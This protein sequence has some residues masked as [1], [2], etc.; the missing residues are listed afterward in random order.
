M[1]TVSTAYFCNPCARA[2]SHQ[3]ERARKLCSATLSSLDL[4][5]LILSRLK[6]PPKVQ[7]FFVFKCHCADMSPQIVNRTF[8]ICK[9]Q[10]CDLYIT[11]AIYKSHFCDLYIT[12][13]IYK[14]HFCDLYITFAIYKSHFCDLYITFTICKSHFCDLYITFA[15]YKSHFCDLY[16]T[17]A[18]Y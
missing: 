14:S 7:V 17:F 1:L 16:I 18:I 2:E 11:F 5:A 4:S 10:F 8:T 6:F 15:I 12:F 9:L 13:A 3:Q